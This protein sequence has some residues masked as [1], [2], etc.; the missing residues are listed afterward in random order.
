MSI[1]TWSTFTSDERRIFTEKNENGHLL[2][3]D[4]RKYLV[5]LEITVWS[6]P[7]N[8]FELRCAFEILDFLADLKAVGRAAA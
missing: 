7:L 4:E 5:E 8:D 6:R 2:T 3:E 1:R